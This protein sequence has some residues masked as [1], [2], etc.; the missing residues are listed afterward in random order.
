MITLAKDQINKA[1]RVQVDD[2]YHACI[3]GVIGV[4]AMTQYVVNEQML[5]EV[6]PADII[7]QPELVRMP[8]TPIMQFVMDAVIGH[9]NSLP[10]REHKDAAVAV[11]KFVGRIENGELAKMFVDRLAKAVPTVVNTPDFIKASRVR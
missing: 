4:A 2:V 10:A 11:L 3:A 8:K 1:G 9:I 5:N 7:A 6:Q